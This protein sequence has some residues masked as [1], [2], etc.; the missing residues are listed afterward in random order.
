MRV[1]CA[2]LGAAALTS[3][4]PVIIA[5]GQSTPWAVAVDNSFVYWTNVASFG[6][7]GPDGSVARAP[8]M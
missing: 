8:K 2:A 3:G 4:V 1:L 6:V 5:S 7:S